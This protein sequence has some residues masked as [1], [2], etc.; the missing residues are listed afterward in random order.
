[1]SD[2][3]LWHYATV[4]MKCHVTIGRNWEGTRDPPS[5]HG[6]RDTQ[7]ISPGPSP[8]TVQWEDGGQWTTYP[9][10]TRHRNCLHLDLGLYSLSCIR[11]QRLALSHLVG[12]ATDF[13]RCNISASRFLLFLLYHTVMN[14]NFHSKKKA[15][16]FL[17]ST[18][19]S[20]FSEK[21]WP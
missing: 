13:M 4:S 15:F 9:V 21:K 17:W 10:L 12:K 18:L 8:T 6:G 14:T 5:S 16:P 1:M 7:E 3:W 2:S 19:A 11:S 20:G